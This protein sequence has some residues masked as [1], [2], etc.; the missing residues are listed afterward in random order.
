MEPWVTGGLLEVVG[1]LVLLPSGC[2][3]GEWLTDAADSGVS[4]RKGR[5]L[6]RRGRRI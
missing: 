3:E 2:G 6:R 5:P 1:F 4:A